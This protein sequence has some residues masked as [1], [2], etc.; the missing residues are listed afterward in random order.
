VLV[1]DDE[2]TIRG[3][4]AQVLRLDGHDATEAGSAEDG[5]AA[6]HARPFPI[7]MSDVVMGGMS[8]LDLLR[9]IRAI[10]SEALVVIMTSQASLEIAT[11]AMRQGAYDFLIKPFE[12]LILI[13]T[14]VKR[15]SDRLALQARNR[16]L[17]SQLE[18]YA[19]ELERLN[20]SLKDQAERDWLTGLPNRRMLRNAL[21]GEISRAM[22]HHRT[23]SLLLLDVDH[24]KN[25]NDRNGHLAGDEVLR[26]VAK[27]LRSSGRS[28]HLCARYG[29]EEFVV[30]LPEADRATAS[31]FAERI[32]QQ[33]E[34][35]SFEGREAQPGGA[36]TVSLGVS[37]FPEDGTDGEALLG[38]ADD[39]L[40]RA[41]EGG[42]NRVEG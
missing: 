26:G 38:R 17:T 9:E 1:V 28:E 31:I 39:A 34:Q 19:R 37:C 4:V 16:L 18:V 7:V 33:I 21:D 30:L 10:D 13:S 15:A 20:A 29:G 41:K 5:L 25:Y 6:F 32:R 22:R 23:F 40:Y 11:T 35:H 24:F 3:V 27:I 42:R 2:P 36:V 8:G 14:V 12:D